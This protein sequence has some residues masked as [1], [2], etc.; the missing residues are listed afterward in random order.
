MGA[1]SLLDRIR[2]LSDEV[3]ECWDWKGALQ[4]GGCTPTIRQGRGTIAVRRALAIELGLPL[5]GRVA[6]ISCG[7][8]LCVRPEHVQTISRGKLQRRIAVE[9][10]MHARPARARKLAEKARL[11]GKLTE[12]QVAEIRAAEGLTQRQLAAQFGISQA[13]VSG[14]R[15]GVKW[16]DYRNPW[17]QLM[18]AR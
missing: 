1:V 18:G 6:T 11:T 15:R 16:K 8:R 13:T 7:N 4:R 5:Q 3:G 10:Q 12:A 9:T 17:L 2:A 14:I